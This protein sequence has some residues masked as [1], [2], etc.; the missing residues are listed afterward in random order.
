MFLKMSFDPFIKLVAPEQESW[1]GMGEGPTARLSL[2][3]LG[4]DA[5]P[6][7]PAQAPP[8]KAYVEAV[9]QAIQASGIKEWVEWDQ[10]IFEPSA[11]A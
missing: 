2:R 1:V 6:A 7:F 4:M 10:S 8:S 5:G 9:R 3:L 11:K